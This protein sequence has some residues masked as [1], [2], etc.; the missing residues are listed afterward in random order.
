MAATLL[1]ISA[2]LGAAFVWLTVRFFNRADQWEWLSRLA[3][4]LML[5]LPIG[6]FVISSLTLPFLDR[7]WLGE[8]ALLAV[9][10]LPKVILARWCQDELVIRGMH[11]AGLSR[12]SP[13]PDS[14]A[15]RPWGLLLAYVLALAPVFACVW[16][17]T[18]TQPSY[19]RLAWILAGLAV[20]DYF[21]TLLL[22]GGPGFSI[23]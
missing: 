20:I 22:A 13:S 23:Y 16:F 1:A 15:S 4:P 18:G 12:G 19:R 9:I 8:I 6:Y 3:K 2:A 17:R 10:Q 5:K 11:W 14:I 21:L 7:V